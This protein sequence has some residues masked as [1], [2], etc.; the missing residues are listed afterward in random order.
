ME[1]AGPCEVDQVYVLM[2]R[3]DVL[4]LHPG[5]SMQLQ[6]VHD[7]LAPLPHQLNLHPRL[8]PHLT[9]RGLIRQLAL[10]DVPARRKPHPELAVEVQEYLTLSHHEDRDGEVPAS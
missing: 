5:W 6:W 7:I 2:P 10:L 9:H 3:F 4:K 1:P 8:L